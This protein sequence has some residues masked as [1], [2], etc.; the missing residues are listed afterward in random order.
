MASYAALSSL[1]SVSTVMARVQSRAD[2]SPPPPSA[3]TADGDGGGGGLAD[4]D[5]TTLMFSVMIVTGGVIILVA[6]AAL[7]YRYESCGRELSF[8]VVVKGT[9]LGFG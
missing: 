3:S 8:A 7:G 2:A 1:G 4:A 6:T 5:E 9:G